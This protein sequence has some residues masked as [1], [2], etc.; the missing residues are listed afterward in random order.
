MSVTI[1]YCFKDRE[2]ERVK[3]SVDSLANQSNK[4]FQIHFIDYGSE[5]GLANEIQSYLGHF[6]NISYY[7]SHS[8]GLP[9]N[10]SHALNIGVRLAKTPYIFTADID[11]VF[12]PNFVEH[13]LH[14]TNEEDA[15]F[16][17]CYLTHEK[18]SDWDNIFDYRNF[19]K[20]TVQGKGLSLI[21]K[22]LLEEIHG[23]DEFYNFWGR[24]DNDLYKRLELLGVAPKFIDEPCLMYHQWHPLTQNSQQTLPLKWN[25]YMKN[26]FMAHD[27][28][29]RNEAGWGKLLSIEDRPAYKYRKEM[30]LEKVNFSQIANDRMLFLD[31]LLHNKFSSSDK[32]ALS[33]EANN[34]RRFAQS[35]SGKLI[36]K[37]NGLLARISDHIQIISTNRDLYYSVY[38]I[39]DK[40]VYFIQNH[41]GQIEDYYC[42]VNTEK[43]QVDL[44]II[45][46]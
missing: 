28:M 19:P 34:L 29:I 15:V 7:Y 40:I 32:I 23:Y 20:T 45:K 14:L 44:V 6:E 1:I 2:V 3:R 37:A 35:T 8:E 41:L 36:N 10:R 5:Q 26:Y 27:S 12:A 17:P 46:K 11:L 33:V 18:F 4:N 25:E 13:L 22:E 39:R 42:H 38:D 43:N 16:M 31:T 9:W 24:E 21:K 30:E